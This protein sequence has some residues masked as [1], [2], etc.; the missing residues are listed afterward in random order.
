MLEQVLQK[1]W[2]KMQKSVE[3]FCPQYVAFSI[4]GMINYPV[5]Y[6]IWRYFALQGYDSF[7][8]RLIATLACIVL[9]LKNHWPTWAKPWFP[10]YWYFTLTFCLPFFFGYLLLMNN[11]SPI[12]LMAH[13]T[14]LFWLILLV[15]WR[16]FIKIMLIG[17]IASIVL[18]LTQDVLLSIN[19]LGGVIA[20]YVGSLVVGGIFA[21]NKEKLDNEKT[22]TAAAL[23]ASIAHELR[24]PLAAINASANGVQQ[25]LPDLL[26][27]YQLAKH[28]NLP[29][30][31]FHMRELSDLSFA[32]DDIK[33]E[34][35]YANT[36]INMLL[37]NAKH[38]HIAPS[39]FKICS[40]SYCIEEALRRYP[41][42]PHQR[43][44][45]V[46]EKSPDFFFNGSELFTIH[47]LFNLLKN[48][49]HHIAVARKGNI[50]IWLTKEK[51]YHKLHFRD[52]GQGISL[53]VLPH[54]FKRFFSQ[55]AH[56][57][58][59]GLAYCKII[60]QAYGG[61]IVCHSTE[62]EYVE[63]ILSFPTVTSAQLP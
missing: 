63:F 30:K 58:G 53:A 25:Y 51:K 11:G 49:L 23:S 59:I 7:L 22:Q 52:T 6:V 18:F 55:T 54:I 28:K 19:N 21:H 35:N 32:L 31:N 27:T 46:W 8:L 57:T 37:M 17:T 26:Q 62:G 48:A 56:G 44:L 61:D 5:Y 13:I 36:I 42:F 29:V 2:I 60:M 16:G 45:I 3:G 34:T 1:E 40:I 43:S 15:D 24:T 41:F 20:Q 50:T 9:I 14:I 33:S 39:E 38:S 47:V 10:L 4:F 12:W